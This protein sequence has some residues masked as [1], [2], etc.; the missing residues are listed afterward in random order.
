MNTEALNSVL[1]IVLRTLW[2]MLGTAG[3][4]S[5]DELKKFAGGLVLIGTIAYH[6]YQRHQG[7]K[8]RG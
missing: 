6:A 3:M 1:V 7:K 4:A 2:P 8:R 5:D